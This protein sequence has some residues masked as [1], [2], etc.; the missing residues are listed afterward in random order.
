VKPN[1]GINE[2]Q[3]VQ[4]QTLTGISEQVDQGANTSGQD[5]ILDNPLG[6]KEEVITL[7]PQEESNINWGVYLSYGFAVVLIIAFVFYMHWVRK[8]NAS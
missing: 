6:Q 8:K 7:H 4:D 1:I 3:Q 5:L 2:G